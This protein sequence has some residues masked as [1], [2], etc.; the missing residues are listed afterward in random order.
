MKLVYIILVSLVFTKS[1]AKAEPQRDRSSYEVI[2]THQIPEGPNTA[3]YAN[4]SANVTSEF[5]YGVL[6]KD[7]QC[8]APW[9]KKNILKGNG[10]APPVSI[11]E[12]GADLRFHSANINVRTRCPKPYRIEGQTTLTRFKWQTDPIQ[13]RV[14]DGANGSLLKEFKN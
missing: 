4:T 13:I 3:E 2:F 6:V 8:E 9:I 1:Y 14:F 11:L 5:I 12:F 7:L 10:Q